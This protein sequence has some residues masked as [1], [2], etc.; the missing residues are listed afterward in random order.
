MDYCDATDELGV[1]TQDPACVCAKA[2]GT[3]LNVLI[4]R[5]SLDAGGISCTEFCK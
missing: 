2:R 1:P 4:K 5:T 3:G